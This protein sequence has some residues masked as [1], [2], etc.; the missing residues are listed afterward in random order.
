MKLT[1]VFAI[2]GSG[3]KNRKTAEL[4]R[5]IYQW[6]V[7]TNQ[8]SR[9]PV[10]AGQNALNVFVDAIDGLGDDEAILIAADLPIGIPVEPSDVYASSD[11]P[12]F[13]GWLD[14]IADR[15]RDNAWRESMIAK[16]VA[17]RSPDQP[18][19]SLGKGD[20]RGGWDGKR[21]C[22]LAAKAESIYCVDHGPKQ[23]GKSALQF[24]WDVMMPIRAAYPGQTAVW[25]MEDTQSASVIFAECYPALCQRM[26]FGGN[27]SK[28]NALAVATS[29]N[30]LSAD[31]DTRSMA[32][33][34]TWIHAAS[35]EDE[36]DMFVT[37]LAIARM[38]ASGRDL[39]AHPDDEAIRNLE[40]WILGQSFDD[41]TK[42]PSQTKSLADD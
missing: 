39:L 40:G 37:A 15:C 7:A 11:P 18:F 8:I 23:V 21:Q 9:V 16:G 12:T 24:W 22:D 42:S 20:Q 5:P 36:F 3:D 13:L 25:P 34:E 29:L 14:G 10:V 2:D 27:V 4:K 6:S 28:R 17:N 30:R 26:V 19:V 32:K 38:V 1:K 41:E 33:T 31:P 35:S